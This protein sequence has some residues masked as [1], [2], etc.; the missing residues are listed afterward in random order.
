MLATTRQ[1]GVLVIWDTLT[2]E[3]LAT[4]DTERTLADACWAPG[5]DR[6]YAVGGSGAACF[7]TSALRS[8]IR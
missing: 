1:S 5:G 6:I 3:Q 8:S 2:W 7:D 4:A